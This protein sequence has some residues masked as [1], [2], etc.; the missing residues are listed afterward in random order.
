MPSEITS[1]PCAFLSAILRSSWANRY[2]G[3]RS[4]RLL[5]LI[6]LLDELFA[7]RRAVHAPRPAGQ[8]HVQV[9]PHLHL[10]VAAVE[11]HRN[12]TLAAVQHVSD[13]GSACA[14]A[15]REGLA[16]A[17]L[18]YARGDLA[19]PVGAPERD[20]GPVGEEVAGFDRW[21]KLRQVELP[22]TVFHL[23]RALRVADRD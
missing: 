22:E 7:Q 2:G 8:R 15:R 21:P 20:V 23:D 11:V 19:F 13:R 5:G 17:A 16:D 12:G 18:E 9:L 6:Q 4:R 14:R 1:M 10:E 3:I